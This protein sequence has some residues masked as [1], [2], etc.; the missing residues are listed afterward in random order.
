MFGGSGLFGDLPTAKNE[1]RPKPVDA[2][3]DTDAQRGDRD[4]PTKEDVGD[5]LSQAPGPSFA[6]S[7]P[8]GEKKKPVSL[9]G[10]LGVAGTTMAF[11]P[12]ALRARKRQAQHPQA[13]RPVVN[14][15]LSAG[16]D[17]SA[18]RVKVETSG[19]SPLESSS[20][21][22]VNSDASRVADREGP[23]DVHAA[24]P[25]NITKLSDPDLDQ[26][27]EELG[28]SKEKMLL[29]T[30]G[31]SKDEERQES[32]SLRHLHESVTDPYDP[33]VPND[34]LAYRERKKA[35]VV[36]EEMERKALEQ[37]E[38]QR[39]M[40]ERIEE[41]R[42]KAEATGDVDK[43]V[44]SRL[45][46][47]GGGMG[48]AATESSG[49]ERGR[50]RGRGRGMANLPAW[51]VKKQQEEKEKAGTSSGNTAVA[52]AGKV[53][54]GQFDDAKES[55][56]VP[57]DFGGQD[58]A[59]R[60]VVLSNMV[61]P[62][63]VDHELSEEVKEECESTCGPVKMVRVRDASFPAQLQVRV[64][65]FFDRPEHATKASALFQGRKFGDRQISARLAFESD[66]V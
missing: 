62:G 59:G 26:P 63:E 2:A 65:V 64:F 40:R 3:A 5:K 21:E 49:L 61:A 52:V 13:Q 29:M 33:L 50:G 18:K 25:A 8:V 16:S 30:G 32:E 19:S 45:G 31:G 57:L 1:R 58:T 38:L 6:P 36:R 4:N 39:K 9:V 37:I 42:R 66:K 27:T 10:A 56:S 54:K 12:A 43:I 48:V 34:Y 23:V 53:A 20:V 46:P 17:F 47:Q 7:A 51:L 11:V 55:S 41:E 44:E 60:L 15:T 28:T 22:V 24:A 35:E 14:R